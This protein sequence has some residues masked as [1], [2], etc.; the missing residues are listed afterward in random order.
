MKLI[1]DN[2]II[3]EDARFKVQTPEPIDSFIDRLSEG[4]ETKILKCDKE[5]DA[6]TA[7]KLEFD[8][9]SKKPE[10]MECFY[11]RVHGK[12]SFDDTMRMAY[13][14]S[15]VDGEARRAI[16]AVGYKWLIL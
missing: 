11:M 2:E 9:L 1:M 15:A 16:E 13:L 12:S 7:L 8:S 5:I 3:K 6:K 4:Q 14:I 10:F